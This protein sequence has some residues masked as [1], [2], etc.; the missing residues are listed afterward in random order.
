MKQRLDQTLVEKGFFLSRAQAQAA[1]MAGLVYLNGQKSDKAGQLVRPEDQLEVKGKEHP[2]VGRGGLKLAKALDKFTVDPAG[3]IALDIGAS[4]GGFTDCLLQRGAKKV[5]AVDVGYGQLAW[6][7]RQD[8]RVVVVERTNARHLTRDKLYNGKDKADLAVIDVSFISLAKILP[9]VYDLL[10]T[11]AEV[12]AL[13]KPQ[14]EADR[15]QVGKGGIVRDQ[16]VREAV[17]VKVKQAAVELGFSVAGLTDSPIA[18][19]DG[20][21]EFLI[22]LRKGQ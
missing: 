12:L 1:I 10:Q 14:F 2:Y 19:A 5:Y 6:K 18:G 11:K 21:K 9:A 22:Y 4:T 8:E 20:N 7:L 17:I 13:I 3:R 15:D 16:K